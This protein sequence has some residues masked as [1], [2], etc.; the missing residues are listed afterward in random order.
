MYLTG[1][2]DS[3]H[4][5]C[6]AAM[7][8]ETIAGL[9]CEPVSALPFLEYRALSLRPAPLARPLVIAISASGGTERVVSGY[10]G[11]PPAAAR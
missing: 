5:A 8:F 6:A 9:R 10:R 4:A 11:G 2:G 1:D 3:Y 7:A